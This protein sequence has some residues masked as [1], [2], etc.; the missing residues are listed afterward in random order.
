MAVLA[1]QDVAVTGLDEIVFA[2]AA[3]GGD[4]APCGRG[5]VLLVANGDASSHTLTV[6]TPGT[7]KGIP[8][9]DVEVAIAA[10]ETAAVPMDALAYR[11]PSTLRASL[12]YDA[13]TDVTVAVLALP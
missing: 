9:D 5:I 6:T 11:S 12:S 2:A 8:I 7:V 4:E 1:A 10:G 13:V 3:A